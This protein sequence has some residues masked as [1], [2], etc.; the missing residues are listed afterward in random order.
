MVAIER[1]MGPWVLERQRMPLT[2]NVAKQSTQM[3]KMRKELMDWRA[4]A[5]SEAT[6]RGIVI[7]EPVEVYVEHYRPN[8]A[9]WPDTGAPILAVKAIIDGMV[10]ADALPDDKSDTVRWLHFGPPTVV[11]YHALKVTFIVARIGA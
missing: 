5:H 7:P 8:R 4:W 6:A 11:G 1:P 10:D 9:G 2:L 3:W